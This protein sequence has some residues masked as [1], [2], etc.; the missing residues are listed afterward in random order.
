MDWYVNT[1]PGRIW[2]KLVDL[3]DDAYFSVPNGC[4]GGYNNE[5]WWVVLAADVMK[6]AIEEELT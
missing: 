5:E 1:G 2:E 4:L 3:E 6:E